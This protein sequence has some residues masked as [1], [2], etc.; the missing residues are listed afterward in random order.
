MVN[1]IET[2]TEIIYEGDLVL[3][4]D[5]KTEKNL[6]VHGDI[7]GKYGKRYNI[8]AKNIYAENIDAHNINTHNIYADNIICNERLKKTK[9]SKTIAYSLVQNRHEREKKEQMEE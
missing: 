8:D 4:S 2:E 7:K 5:F 3:E 6:I 9:N 1:K